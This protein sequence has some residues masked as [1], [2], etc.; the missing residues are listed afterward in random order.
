MDAI[1]LAAQLKA[2]SV[3]QVTV[4][5]V[6]LHI[7]GLTGRER[8]ILIDRAK[9]QDP[10]R[11]HEVV[12]FGACAPNGERLFPDPESLIDMDGDILVKISD[13]ILKAS[14]L[15]KE[16]KDGAADGAEDD[17]AKN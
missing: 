14:K 6:T 11:P 12:A 15:F 17:A 13:E 1:T 16:R 7:R 10:L 5:G 8:Q 9:A 3:K 2:H 4:E